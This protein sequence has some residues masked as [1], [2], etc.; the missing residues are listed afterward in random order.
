MNNTLSDVTRLVQQAR[1]VVALT[2]AGMSAESG[3]PTF[4]G[5]DGLW[6]TFRAGDL[7]TPEAFARDPQLVWAWYRWRREKIAAARPNPGH[8]ALAKLERRLSAFTLLTQ[9]VDGLHREAGSRAIIE[10][11]GNLWRARCSA[12][13]DRVIEDRATSPP[14]EPP[15]C[16]CGALLRPD[17]VWF[18]ES[19]NPDH[20]ERAL[21]A[22]RTCDVLLV[23]GTSAIV[24]PVAAFPS[25]ARQAGAR[26]VEINVADTPLTP[27][28]DVVIR[29]PAGSVLSELERAL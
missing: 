5:T 20:V 15:R 14:A 18:G 1:A 6:R 9:N 10:L 25:L 27:Q 28:A 22:V 16:A 12:E 7:A 26:I 11:H 13:P 24:Y 17:V 8:V 19:L 29:G 4:R 2:G 3:V 23:I 21:A